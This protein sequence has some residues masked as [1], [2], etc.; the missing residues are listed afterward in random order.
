MHKGAAP[1][2][3]QTKSAC[4]PLFVHIYLFCK[5]LAKKKQ[6][7]KKNVTNMYY[8]FVK[9]KEGPIQ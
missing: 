3:A 2:T 8:R 4:A 9:T 7:F 6:H 1:A 5:H